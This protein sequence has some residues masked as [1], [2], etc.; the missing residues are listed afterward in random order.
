MTTAL[1]SLFFFFLLL[2][3]FSVDLTL[4]AKYFT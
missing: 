4:Y 3:S 1:A 2:V